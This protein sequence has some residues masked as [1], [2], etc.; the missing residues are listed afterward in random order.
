MK[1]III[2]LLPIFVFA[3]SFLIS[4]IP[5]PKTYIQDLDPYPCDEVC[6]QEYIDKGMIFSFL[7]HADKKLTN[8][9]QNEIRM[10]NISI[11]N[12]GSK[13]LSKELRIAMLLPYKIIGRYAA[14]TTNS[15]FAYLMAKNHA[16]ELKSYKIESE[17]IDEIDKAI[18]KIQKDGF[19]YVVAPLTK[20]GADILNKLDPQLYV[21][22]PTINKKDTNS[23]STF[24]VYGG[25]D[26]KAQSDMLLKE[27]VSPLVIFHDKSAIGKKLSLYE[28]ESFKAQKTMDKNTTDIF[29]KTI[30]QIQ[31]DL[32]ENNSSE[33][34]IIVVSFSIPRRTTNL[35]KQLKDNPTIVEGSYFL[36]TPIVKSGMIMS[37]L[38][39][40]DLN[41]TNILSTQINYDPLLLSMTQYTDRKDMIIANSITKQNNF[42]I[43]SNALLSNDIVY[44]WINYTTVVG[45]DYFFNLITNDAREYNID[46]KDNQMIYD[47]ELLQPSLSRFIKY[48]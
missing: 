16:F 3:K 21:Y 35:E 40:Y 32:D 27:A 39:L 17:N 42:L 30:S 13:M 7:S 12:I 20:K 9:Q 8:K 29:D 34:N 36:N 5:L 25:I 6:L 47:I 19:S 37:Q 43:E 41:A 2:L 46:I 45:V 23:S 11:L 15:V 28:E 44:D 22:F 26:Y 38:T 31:T 1:K 48:K 10:M 18:K 4:D 33:E 14:S 24:F